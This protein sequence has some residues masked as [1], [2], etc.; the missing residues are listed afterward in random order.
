MGFSDSRWS[1]IRCGNTIVL[2][3]FDIYKIAEMLNIC[4][5]L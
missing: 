1:L 4:L 3:T 2:A 5:D